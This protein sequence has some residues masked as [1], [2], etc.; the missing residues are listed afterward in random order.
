MNKNLI[1]SFMSGIFPISITRANLQASVL[2][3]LGLV[4]SGCLP[5]LSRVVLAVALILVVASLTGPAFR[6]AFP[7]LFDVDT[8]GR[9]HLCYQLTNRAVRKNSS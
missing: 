2:G 9:L 3:T 1:Q 4:A 8:C 5:D 7:F 6:R